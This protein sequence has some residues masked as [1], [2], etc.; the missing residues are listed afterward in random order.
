M[1]TDEES[2]PERVPEEHAPAGPIYAEPEGR[3][4]AGDSAR[5][6]RADELRVNDTAAQLQE[7]ARLV[8]ESPRAGY[9]PLGAAQQ[10]ASVSGSRCPLQYPTDERASALRRDA[11]DRF[12]SQQ[13][14]HAKHVHYRPLRAHG[15]IPKPGGRSRHGGSLFV[16]KRD[17]QSATVSEQPHALFQLHA[18]VLVRRGKH[19]GDTG[20][21]HQSP[22]READREQTPSVGPS[23]HL[24]RAHQESNVQVLDAR[25]CP[26]CAG[27]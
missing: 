1:Y 14:A 21:D 5:P 8:S 25:V 10:S 24:H 13:G 22:S 17:R 11:G 18:L 9:L 23:H 27:N 6:S 16:L 20:T 7:R 4:A 15:H 26:L 2:H 12:H 19:R 3:H